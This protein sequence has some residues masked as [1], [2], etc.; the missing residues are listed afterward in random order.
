MKADDFVVMT[1]ALVSNPEYRPGVDRVI[2]LREIDASGIT[3]TDIEMIANQVAEYV[4][5][6]R[7]GRLAL[8]VGGDSPLKFGLARMFKA[9][10][11]LQVNGPVSVSESLDAALAWL[12]EAESRINLNSEEDAAETAQ[13]GDAETHDRPTD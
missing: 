4:N 7:T 13:A 3:A 8:V 12:A 5:A 6:S 10:F 11:G 9:Y 1:E 2:D